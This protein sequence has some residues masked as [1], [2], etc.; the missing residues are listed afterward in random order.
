MKTTLLATIAFVC[1][2]SSVFAA[3]KVKACPS[4]LNINLSSVELTADLSLTNQ[5]GTKCEYIGLDKN[6]S[7]IDAVISFGTR[8]GQ[9]NKATLMIKFFAED[10]IS[11]TKLKSVSSSTIELDSTRNRRVNKVI[12]TKIYKAG[13]SFASSKTILK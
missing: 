3:P 12:P 9:T 4:E 1:L 13:K 5:T 10:M 8:K 11:I 6:N 7:N 2:T